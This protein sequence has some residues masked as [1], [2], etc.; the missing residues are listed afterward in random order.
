MLARLT[1]AYGTICGLAGGSLTDYLRYVQ[2]AGEIAASADDEEL[3]AAM[4]TSLAAVK[5]YEGKPREIEA[6]CR[7]GL[8]VTGPDLTKGRALMGF[9]PRGA[10]LFFLSVALGWGGRLAEARARLAA[11]QREVDAGGEREVQTWF[12][13]LWAH[14]AYM[15]G[16]PDSGMEQARHCF[17]LS[18][19]LGNGSSRV[20]AR[21]SLGVAHLLEGN[22]D[23]AVANCE[24]AVALIEALNTQ[25]TY[26]PQV[27]AVLSEAHC[28]AGRTGEARRIAEEALR[29]TSAGGYGTYAVLAHMALA[30]ALLAEEG[31]LSAAD[32]ERTLAEANRLIEAHDIGGFRPQLRELEANLARREGRDDDAARLLTE[33]LRLYRD[34]GATGHAARLEAAPDPAVRG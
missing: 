11:G 3:R 13:Q 22:Y 24:S 12:E 16:G 29:I 1:A 19:K 23:E 31:H 33:A 7:A 20:L 26:L 14:I 5:L 30:R 2:E 25:R 15:T 32:I 27:Q 9:S 6:A 8:A 34:V 18:E 28:R 4:A 21:T 17:E 10:L